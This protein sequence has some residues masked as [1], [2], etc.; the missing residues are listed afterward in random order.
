[1][2]CSLLLVDLE[3]AAL[4]R[5]QLLAHD[6][7]AGARHALGVD[8]AGVE[9]GP[10]ARA[11]ELEDVQP[12]DAR[13][14]ARQPEQ[15]ASAPSMPRVSPEPFLFGNAPPKLTMPPVSVSQIWPGTAASTA[16]VRCVEKR[17]VSE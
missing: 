1:M 9:A 7:V 17:L 3:A 2:P 12:R 13:V 10:G 4:G 8:Q 16:R 14:R 11:G 5:V 15:E 6:D